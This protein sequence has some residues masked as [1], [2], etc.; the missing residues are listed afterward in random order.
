MGST[1]TI[2]QGARA[3]V[4]FATDIYSQDID[5]TTV[6]AVEFQVVRYPDQSTAVWPGT[7]S[8]IDPT[9]GHISVSYELA[10]DG[11]DMP[12]GDTRAA[13]TPVLTLP[14]GSIQATV[15]NINSP[16]Q[17]NYY[18]PSES[19]SATV[20][21]TATAEG[22]SG[23]RG[24][25]GVTGSTGP[26][27]ALLG[28]ALL[29]LTTPYEWVTDWVSGNVPAGTTVAIWT[30]LGSAIAVGEQVTLFVDISIQEISGP[31]FD[32]WTRTIRVQNNSGVITCPDGTT[33]D[34][35]TT[36]TPHSTALVGLSAAIQISGGTLKVFVSAPPGIAVAAGIS[37]SFTRR[38]QA[39]STGISAMEPL[40]AI[41][42]TEVTAT[43]A[44]VGLSS[45]TAAGVIVGGI[46]YPM[47]GAV[48]SAGTVTGSLTVLAVGKGVAYVTIGGFDFTGGTF[49]SL[50][51]SAPSITSITPNNGASAGGTDVAIVGSGLTG[52]DIPS[53]GGVTTSDGTNAPVPAASIAYVDDEH[54]TITTGSDLPN[55]GT[56]VLAVTTPMGT[57]TK[58]WTVNVPPAPTL[59]T[60]PP[61]AKAGDTITLTGAGF[62]VPGIAVRF[63]SGSTVISG[64]VV[65]SSDTKLTAVVPAIA[66]SGTPYTVTVETAAG[67]SSGLPFYVAPASATWL[68]VPD[69][70]FYTMGSGSNVA[71]WTDTTGTYDAS[72]AVSGSQPIDSTSAFSTSAH[73]VH[74]SGAQQLL[75]SASTLA[76]LSTVVPFAIVAAVKASVPGSGD[77]IFC[78]SPTSNAWGGFQSSVGA[79][80]AAVATA[81]AEV[82]PNGAHMFYG[83][84]VGT[85]ASVSIDDGSPTTLSGPCNGFPGGISIGSYQGGTNNFTGD[86]GFLAVCAAAPS[87]GDLTIFHEISQALYGTP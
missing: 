79:T 33:A 20:T 43:I 64:H 32:G 80:L 11:S 42:S 30:L 70:S 44:G 15:V 4:A 85:T 36:A 56:G 45:G 49:W 35:D 28:T 12:L 60:C 27:G 73:S 52:L 67:L 17:A 19:G 71:G 58:P 76:G 54:A 83:S 59:S 22:F 14:G 87:S 50:L 39:G 62:G 68:W 53:V 82:W 51:D 57:G 74:F 72:Q 26:A 1:V 25:P 31:A 84:A 75:Y 63:T 10:D 6:T 78:A 81:V 21:G 66:A 16:N 8:T 38:L 46:K 3:P 77:S 23:L 48:F 40:Y 34:T 18:A 24:A 69:P 5:L 86:L 7:I 41:Q 55:S 9:A 2:P 65:V 61:M 29:G 47:A 37:A 13:A